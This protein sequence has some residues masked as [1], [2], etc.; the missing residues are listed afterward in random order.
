MLEIEVTALSRSEAVACSIA[1]Q[2]R[3]HDQAVVRAAGAG[4]VHQAVKAIAI[5]IGFL[6]LDGVRAVC[7]P[8]LAGVEVEGT[9]RMVVQ[10]SVEVLHRD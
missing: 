9:E 2:L 10:I 6:A 5:A 4:A 3:D 7:V 8:A 1:D